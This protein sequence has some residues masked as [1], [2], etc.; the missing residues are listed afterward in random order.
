M[1]LPFN[2]VYSKGILEAHQESPVADWPTK[3]DWVRHAFESLQEHGYSISSAYT[4]IKDPSKVNFSYR[5]NLWG[6][7]DLLATGIASFG[8]ASGVHYQNVPEW[9]HYLGMVL[10]E[11]RL[12]LGRAYRPT[13]L[14][15]LIREMIL[16]LK[17]GYLEPA[18]FQA[19]FDSDIVSQWRDVWQE[20][21]QD[22]YV[23]M[24]TDTLGNVVRIELTM[25]GLLRADGLLPAFFE[26]QF[27][28]VRYT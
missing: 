2:T 8:H 13:P 7:A 15:L 22:G 1:E 21:V 10:D 12:P 27:R 4:L 20:Y 14:Q 24:R 25:D 28:G 11:G 5:D 9:E 6:G 23:A 26:P 19:K 3:R 17:R 16:Q 18:Y